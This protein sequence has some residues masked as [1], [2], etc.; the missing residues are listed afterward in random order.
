MSQFIA[1]ISGTCD[2]KGRRLI[3]FKFPGTDYHVPMSPDHAFQL[4]EAL[5]PLDEDSE[6]R[7]FIAMSDRLDTEIKQ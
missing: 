4:M 3:H 7:E 5:Y 2:A 1:S 6:V